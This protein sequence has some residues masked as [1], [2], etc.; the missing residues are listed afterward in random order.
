MNSVHLGCL[1][2]GND[3]GFG[4]FA[5]IRRRLRCAGGWVFWKL[6]VIKVSVIGIRFGL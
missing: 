2:R 5:A 6:R 4:L 3:D 1:L